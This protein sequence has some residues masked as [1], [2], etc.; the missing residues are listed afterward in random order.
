MGQVVS[1]LISFLFVTAFVVF[2]AMTFDNVYT[3]IIPIRKLA[4]KAACEAQDC[5]QPHNATRWDRSFDGV[6]FTIQWKSG[7]V[8][9][10]RCRREYFFFGSRVC[11]A[12]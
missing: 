7:P 12:E 9:T 10:I 2:L 6:V 11:K 8:V 4:E 1:R 3:D 5:K